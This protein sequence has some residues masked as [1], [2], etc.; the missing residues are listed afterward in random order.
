MSVCGKEV[1]GCGKVC[2]REM[3]CGMHTCEETCHDGACKTCRVTRKNG[4]RCGKTFVEVKCGEVVDAFTCVSV[5]GEVFGCGVHRCVEVCHEGVHERCLYDVGIVERCP[6][7]K[8]LLKDIGCVR[9]TCTDVIA[10]C[11]ET[12]LKVLECGHAC[13]LKCHSGPWYTDIP[14]CSF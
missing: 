14:F 3:E 12:C 2:G 5:C 8:K 6:C 7:G 11:G 13:Q 10:T 9:K 1:R 4:C